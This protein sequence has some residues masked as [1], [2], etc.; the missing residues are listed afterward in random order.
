[1]QIQRHALL[2]DFFFPDAIWREN[3]RLAGTTTMGG[4]CKSH[5]DESLCAGS[6]YPGG[7]VPGTVQVLVVTSACTAR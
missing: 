5:N 1:M 4:S 6:L 7:T 2:L 3:V